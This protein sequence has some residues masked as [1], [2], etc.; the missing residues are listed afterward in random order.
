M[1]EAG[2]LRRAAVE[3]PA[4]RVEGEEIV[5]RWRFPDFSS[6]LAAA[7][8]VGGLAERADHHPELRVAWGLLEVRLTTHSANGLT[9]RDLDLASAVQAALQPPSA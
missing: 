7:V 4:W 8:R 5:G 2:L 6:A 3:L 1:V 9:A